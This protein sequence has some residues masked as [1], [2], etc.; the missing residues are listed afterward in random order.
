MNY[1]KNFCE[2]KAGML[3]FTNGKAREVFFDDSVATLFIARVFE[4]IHRRI[5]PLVIEKRKSGLGIEET[6]QWI[7]VKAR[8]V[9]KIEVLLLTE[10]ALF[11]YSGKESEFNHHRPKHPL[12]DKRLPKLYLRL[13]DWLYSTRC[14]CMYVYMNV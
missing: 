8:W 1:G 4:H 10:L 11:S 9:R 14:V 12:V 3:Y 13:R 7:S 2:L 6:H 5:G